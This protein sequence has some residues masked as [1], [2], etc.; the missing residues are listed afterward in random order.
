MPITIVDGFDLRQRGPLD[1]RTV[2][3]TKQEALQKLPA[4]QRYVGLTVY[5]R[6]EKISY[7]FSE[8][9]TDEDFVPA[10]ESSADL[11]GYYVYPFDETSFEDDSSILLIPASQHGLGS[12]VYL[13]C[14][15]KIIDNRYADIFVDFDVDANGDVR[16][17]CGF[18][19]RGRLLLL[20]PLPKVNPQENSS[21]NNPDSG[22]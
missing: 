18:Q 7:R 17:D 5:I 8:G 10:K 1:T 2:F 9:V 4:V 6:Q 13:G 14:A 16:I 19:M 20:S 15:Q 11:P 12:T 3:E 21:E 22:L